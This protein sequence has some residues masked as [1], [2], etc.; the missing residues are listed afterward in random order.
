VLLNVVTYSLGLATAAALAFTLE[1]EA[2]PRVLRLP[3]HSTLP[4]GLTAVAGLLVYLTWSAHPTPLRVGRWSLAPLPLTTSLLQIAV[5][6][7]DWILSGAA[8]F[9][10]L[11]TAHPLSFFAFFGLFILGQIAALIA[12]VPGGLGVFEAVML[13]TLVPPF[14]AGALFGALLAYRVIYFF[15][16]LVLAAI[17][18]G[19]RGILRL[20]PRKT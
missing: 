12:Q 13:A 5:S 3:F 9:V 7:A 8:L 6:L 10:L 14:S 19:A 2:V 11:P 18:L 20:R 4:L 15:L 16:P 1:P 17:L